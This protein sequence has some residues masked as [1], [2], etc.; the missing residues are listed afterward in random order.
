[1]EIANPELFRWQVKLNLH[2]LYQN[3]ETTNQRAFKLFFPE[4]EIECKSK[5]LLMKN[6]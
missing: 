3:I 1:M 6:I 2:Y 4:R 5:S